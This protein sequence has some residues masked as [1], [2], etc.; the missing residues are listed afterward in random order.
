M[1]LGRVLL[2][3]FA[4][5]AVLALAAA[6][7][8]FYLHR[9]AGNWLPLPR[10]RRGRWTGGEVVFC[11]LLAQV[12]PIIFVL[13]LDEVDFF[14]RIFEMHVQPMLRQ[15]LMLAP[16]TITLL[17]AIH[18]WVLH[19]VHGTHPTHVGLTLAR[20]R[21]NVRLGLTAFCLA[22]PV[23]LGL[24]VLALLVTIHWPQQFEELARQGLFRFEWVFLG[25]HAVVFAPLLEEWLF[26]GLLQGWL[27]RAS[28]LGHLVV[29]G[30]ALAAGSLPFYYSLEQ[31]AA[32]PALVRGLEAGAP[33]ALA[34]IDPQPPP[35]LW[36]SLVFAIVMV[37]IYVAGELKLWWPVF[38]S[39]L[40]HFVEQPTANELGVSSD[41]E[42]LEGE[43][44]VLLPDGPRWEAFKLANARWAIVGSAVLFALSHEAW[45]SAVAL[46]PLG[47][48]LGWLAYRTQSLIP[49][50]VL[51]ALFNA[52][53][54]VV[55]FLSTP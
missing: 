41:A 51:H 12:L 33:Q 39:G 3:N 32:H 27:R 44:P 45:P 38:Q 8:A 36:E 24:Y 55:L 48:V 11:I 52:V 7:G 31:R 18:F 15:I 29:A 28:P 5:Y 14:F 1:D 40:R 53:A 49:G 21:S 4:V 25:L 35:I 2:L 37:G 23:V 26:R 6:L 42:E 50:I 17:F 20:W 19:R 30:C 54:F 22:T 46:M 43:T 10:L 13:A 9:T 16:L 34:A 47:M